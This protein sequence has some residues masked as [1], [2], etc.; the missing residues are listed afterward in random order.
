[1][2]GRRPHALD[3]YNLADQVEKSTRISEGDNASQRVPHKR[4]RSLADNI[5]ES[6]KIENVLGNG[7]ECARRPL[8]VAVAAK[9]ERVDMIISAQSCGHAVPT[10]RVIKA[11]D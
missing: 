8:A 4:Q 1:M 9:V 3:S 5:A 11:S 2:R 6:G 7:I 10:P